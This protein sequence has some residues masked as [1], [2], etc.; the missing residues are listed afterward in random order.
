MCCYRYALLALEQ[1]HKSGE[2]YFPQVEQLQI[3]ASNKMQEGRQHSTIKPFNV[4]LQEFQSIPFSIIGRLTVT[5][6]T[7]CKE[8]LTPRDIYSSILQ[9]Q[10][11]FTNSEPFTSD[12][13]ERTYEPSYQPNYESNVISE[14]TIGTISSKT[15]HFII[16]NENSL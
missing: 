13:Y 8:F 15:D 4:L 2:I 7:E 12:S 16:F 6:S 10:R 5:M 14:K 11:G 1:I 9:A 3:G